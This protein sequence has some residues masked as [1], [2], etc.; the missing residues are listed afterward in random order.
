MKNKIPKALIE[1]IKENKKYK[2][3]SN[4][5]VIKEIQNYMKRYQTDQEDIYDDK[6]AIKVIR[7]ELHRLYS[8]YQ[9]KGKKKRGELLKNLEILIKQHAP[10]P[11]VLEVINILLKIT[12]STIERLP[13]YKKLY[14]DVFNITGKPK[15]IT[16][17]GAGLNPLSFPLTKLPKSTT[18]HSY[19]IDTEDITFLNKFYK[20]LK[21]NGTANILDVRDINMLDKL[22]NSDIIFMF[23]LYDLIVPKA[24]KQKKLGEEII[25]ILITKTNYLIVSFATKTLT[26]KSMKLPRRIGFE[27]MLD[28][29][30]LNYNLIETDNE[31]YYV[32]SKHKL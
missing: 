8:S 29:N 27:M 7:K 28:R 16:D 15:S 30:Q 26:R 12:L 5:I 11:K 6:F 24:K 1:K 17:L 22:P 25:N 4:D 19:D 18:Y 2:S 32:I 14:K 23:K 21:I 20:T 13:H 3:I 10:E 9:T 31:I